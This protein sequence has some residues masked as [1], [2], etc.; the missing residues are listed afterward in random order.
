[1]ELGDLVKFAANAP[2]GLGGKAGRVTKRHNANNTIEVHCRALSP[3]ED[4]IY[5][6]V[7]DFREI[8][9]ILEEP[10]SPVRSRRGSPGGRS[11]SDRPLPARRRSGGVSGR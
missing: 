2:L 6:D 8:C 10:R 1:M 3:R 11:V 7:P 4:T 5:E 9:T